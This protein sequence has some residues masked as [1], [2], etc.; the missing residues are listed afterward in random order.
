MA[1]HS[2]SIVGRFLDTSN[3]MRQ[4]RF[5]PARLLAMVAIARTSRVLHIDFDPPWL[6]G[7]LFKPADLD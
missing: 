2:L 7:G 1:V 5:R 4:L 3:N 6:G